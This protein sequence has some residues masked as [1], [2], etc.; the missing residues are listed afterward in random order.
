MNKMLKYNPTVFAV[1]NDYKIFIPVTKESVMWIKV[2][3]E[4]Y[5]DHSNGVLRSSVTMHKITVPQSTLNAAGK[6]TVCFR[7]MIERKPYFSV[8]SDVYEEEFSFYPLPEEDFNAYH[9]SDAHGAVSAP[10]NSA[11]G[12]EKKYGKIN[13]LILN[14]DVI[15]HSGDI[16]NFD[17]IYEICSLISGGTVP[18]V[19]SRGNHDTRGKFAEN[20][21]DYTPTR[22]GYS[23]FS[24]RLGTLWG[25]VLDCGEDKLDERTEYDSSENTPTKYRGL[26]RFHS[27]RER[28]LSFLQQTNLE[29]EKKIPFAITHVCPIK[30]TYQAGGIFDIERELY[31]MWNE[32]LERMDIK[33]ML[34]GHFHKAFI[35]TQGDER[36]LIDHSY[37]VV[38][39]SAHSEEDLWGAAITLNK[40]KMEVRFTNT[41]CEVMESYTLYFSTKV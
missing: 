18:V 33:F 10:V 36:N 14:G 35:L 13:L 37:P 40:D 25:L 1:G 23:Y 31:T 29:T 6:Y 12:F 28:Q 30:T 15:D 9:I 2:G 16:G 4:C 3:D 34:C 8:T 27:Y 20:I 39:G 32:E 41:A 17:A 26:N 21:A 19:F 5:Y 22:V 7:E 24:F 38:V 11:L